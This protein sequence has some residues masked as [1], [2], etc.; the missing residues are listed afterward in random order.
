MA[1][2]LSQTGSRL[3]QTCDAKDY[4]EILANRNTGRKNSRRRKNDWQQYFYKR[5]VGLYIRVRFNFLLFCFERLLI[6]NLN[7]VRFNFSSWQAPSANLFSTRSFILDG[8]IG[9]MLV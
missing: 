3:A 7:S 4:F 6:C 9:E 5:K 1:V 8:E 2:V